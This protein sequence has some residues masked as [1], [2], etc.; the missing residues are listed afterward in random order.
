MTRCTSP[1]WTAKRGAWLLVS[2]VA[3]VEGSPWRRFF[4]LQPHFSYKAV[5]VPEFFGIRETDPRDT[6]PWGAWVVAVVPRQVIGPEDG[7]SP[8]FER[9]GTHFSAQAG[10]LQKPVGRDSRGGTGRIGAGTWAGI[11]RVL[12]R[13]SAPLESGRFIGWLPR[14]AR[15]FANGRQ[16]LTLRV[17]P[18][19]EDSCGVSVFARGDQARLASPDIGQMKGISPELKVAKGK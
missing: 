16:C 13:R 2:F 4:G 3:L 19:R 18:E 1:Q 7:G 9:S 6:L 8:R 12:T 11:Q 15:L 10:V 17:Y 14:A 5:G